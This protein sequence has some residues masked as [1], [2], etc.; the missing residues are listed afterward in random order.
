VTVDRLRVLCLDIEGGYGGSSRSLFES[1][2]NLDPAGVAVEVWCKRAG[3]IQERYRALGVPCRVTPAMPKV[4]ALP[5]LSRNLVIFAQ[6]ARGWLAARAF[7]RELLAEC[8]RF[9]LVHLNHEA[10]F[11]L[12][13][14]L[15]R[16]THIPVTAHVRTILA[17][18][19]FARWQCRTLANVATRLLFITENERASFER[20]AGRTVSGRVVYNIA[21]PPD[22]PVAPDSRVPTDG[23]FRVASLSNFAWVRGTDRLI[24]VA[25]ALARAG[26]R[27]ILFVVAGSMKLPGGLSGE[28]GR[29]ARAGGSLPDYAKARG[30][31]DMFVFLGHVSNPEATLAGCDAL[32]KPT[33]N[34]DPWGR[35]IIEALAAGKPVITLGRYNRFVEDGVTGV[36]KP[37]FDAPPLAR[38]IARLADD[39]ALCRRLGRAGRDRVATLCNG[40]ARAGELLT[41]WAE[42][43]GR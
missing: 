15:K 9:D 21:E 43:V 1:I 18:S 12:G 8:R 40:P 32:F 42:A 27:D 29:V 5:R 28:I 19:A 34:A 41:V 11:I 17:D 23:R 20:H 6:F 35:D 7:R 13:R 16:R 14:W 36:L 2:R 33:R 31:S 30:V 3:P 25:E 37:T 39:R 10:L 38:E 24:D 22:A 4:S 26:R